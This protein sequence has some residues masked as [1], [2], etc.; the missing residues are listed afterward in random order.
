MLLGAF[1]RIVKQGRARGLGATMITQRS[2]VLNKDLLTQIETLVVLRTTAALDRKAI[3]GWI[4][5]HGQRDEMLASLSG[6]APGE[7]WVWSPW[8]DVVERVRFPLRRTF[9]SAAT[10]K[11][12]RR[13][14]AATL[15]DVDLDALRKRMAD[16][17][18]RAKA[19]DPKELRRQIAELRKEL[20]RAT[21][22][23][24]ATAVNAR[25]LAEKAAEPVVE[26]VEVPVVPLEV[27]ERA[28]RIVLRQFSRIETALEKL[29]DAVLEGLRPIGD[30]LSLGEELE[31]LDRERESLKAGS[32]RPSPSGRPNGPAAP[33]R[34]SPARSVPGTDPP[35]ADGAV[36]AA[37]QAILDALAWFEATGVLSEPTR[38]AVAAVARTSSKSSYFEKN[39]SA[40]RTAGLVA[41]PSA[42]RLALLEAGRS[43][44]RPPDIEPT[45]AALQ[46]AMYEMVGPARAAI[47][48]ALVAAYPAA[49]SRTDLAERAGTSAASSYF[50]KNVSALRTLGLVEYPDRGHVVARDVLFLEGGGR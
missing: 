42:G 31:R 40:L 13:R 18:E 24:N 45:T 20:Q 12:G 19:D 25:R 27:Y 38:P 49:L 39:V 36:T 5:Y 7:A 29:H 6:L 17:V 9:D 30:V 23:S 37:R 1:Q 3:A 22:L 11:V 14:Q 16:A 35:A 28:E 46:D 32:E 4:E 2:A 50:E 41:Y 34:P 15:A 10:P 8:L 44:A 43:V 47:L 48:R 26:R 21:D 33:V